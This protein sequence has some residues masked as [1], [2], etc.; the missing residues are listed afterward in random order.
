M[1][2]P[3]RRVCVIAHRGNR[4][5][6]PE[7]TMV[8]FRQA[9]E[10][11]ADAIETDVQVSLDGVAFLLHDADLSRTTDRAGIASAMMM[12]AITAA[13][14]GSKVGVE[15]RGERI[16]TLAELATLCRGRA[17]LVLD[18]KMDGTI[19]AIADALLAAD[20][21]HDHVSVCT[22]NDVQAH[23]VVTIMPEARLVYIDEDRHDD[24]DEGIAD[25]W[26]DEIVADGYRGVSLEWSKL[27]S[28][29]IRSARS[30]NLPV[31]T[32][33]VNTPADMAA[34]IDSGVEGIITDDPQALIRMLEA[35]DL[36]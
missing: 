22:W 11:G 13:D 30:H 6:A 14:G 21:P 28:A 19:E 25:D 16:P 24:P 12:D 34:A 31:M 32:W 29:A 2:A 9:L 33:T 15:Y 18:L 17:R 23:E 7:N 4:V 27:G 35:R 26:F 36:R 10:I 8:A 1:E 20:F 5:V 3:N